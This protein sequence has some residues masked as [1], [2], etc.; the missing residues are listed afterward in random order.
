MLN[1]KKDIIIFIKCHLP[2]RVLGLIA[3]RIFYYMATLKVDII[4]ISDL[5]LKSAVGNRHLPVC[6]ASTCVVGV[7]CGA[8]KI[9]RLLF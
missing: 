2:D 1:L 3:K 4:D 5:T 8:K 6:Q 7:C 9:I